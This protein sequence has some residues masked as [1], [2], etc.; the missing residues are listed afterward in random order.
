MA[1]NSTTHMLSFKELLDSFIY[2]IPENQRGYS[3]KSKKGS[4][5]SQLED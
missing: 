4:D 2:E 3:W 1:F 5:E